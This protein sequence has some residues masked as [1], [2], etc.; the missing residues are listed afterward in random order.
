MEDKELRWLHESAMVK[1][2]AG[3]KRMFV[4]NVI[5]LIVLLVTNGAWLYYESTFTDEKLVIEAEQ[6]ADGD[7]SNYIIGGNYGDETE[8]QGN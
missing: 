8:S 5:L 4:L 3:N 1:L 7:S 6:Q 2:E